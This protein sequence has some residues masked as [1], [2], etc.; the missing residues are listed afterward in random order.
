M[1]DP[2]LNNPNENANDP[3]SNA[4]PVDGTYAFT[5]RK[6]DEPPKSEP[7]QGVHN[8]WAQD[9]R[10]HYARNYTPYNVEPN[11]S[12][13][14]P[15]PAPQSEPPKKKKKHLFLKVVALIL[16]VAI[17]GSAAGAL[18]YV[19]LRDDS[20]DSDKASTQLDSGKPAK[21]T[22]DDKPENTPAADNADEDEEENKPVSIVSGKPIVT[23]TGPGEYMDPVAVYENYVSACV[24]IST[25]ITTT[26]LF[27]QKTTAPVSGSGFIISPDGY[28]ITNCHVVEKGT[29]I[30]VACYDGSVYTAQLI[31]KD[32]DGDV[33]LLK[34]EP[35]EELNY[36]V[37]GDIDECK[38]GE[39]VCVIGNPLGELDFTM[40]TG[41]ISNLDRSINVDGTYTNMFQLDAAINSGN[42]G[43][44]VFNLK[45]EVIGVATAKYSSTGVE[46]LAFALPIDDVIEKANDLSLYGYV[47]GKAYMGILF[48]NVDAAYAYYNKVPMGVFVDSLEEGG[49][50]ER[51]GIL[52]GD[53]IT[54][55]DGIVVQSGLEL[56]AEIA[57]FKAGDTTTMTVWRDGDTVEIEITFDE[58]IPSKVQEP[59]QSVQTPGY[60]GYYTPGY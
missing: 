4:Q 14:R 10:Q 12:S 9:T 56:K 34:I 37:M 25:E 24:G 31:G 57:K 23:Y 49:C 41:R 43:G 2:Y 17:V 60:G 16:C 59:E 29:T 5:F 30:E 58:Y 27:G 21:D 8:E 44:P 46:G 7:Q 1:Y 20:G 26:N 13:Y 45:G 53:I 19:L 51:A 36:V 40:T 52:P 28:I 15:E 50:A 38:V 54:G 6:S 3:Q 33:A 22:E 35:E 39:E 11:Y 42:S 47:T 48:V 18:T 32:A 55:I